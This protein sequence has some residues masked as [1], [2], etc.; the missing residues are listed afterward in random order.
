MD[1]QVADHGLGSGWRFIRHCVLFAV[2][3]DSKDFGVGLEVDSEFL[4]RLDQNAYQI[5]IEVAKRA[6]HHLK[7]RDFC[8][9]GSHR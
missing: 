3:F 1:D 8:G 5:G 9:A 4:G 6:L 7:Y 2:L